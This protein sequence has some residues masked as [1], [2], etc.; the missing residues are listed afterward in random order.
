MLHLSL[1][2][3]AFIAVMPLANAAPEAVPAENIPPEYAALVP[4]DAA[5]VLWVADPQALLD[6]Y[7]ADAESMH[8]PGE[9]PNSMNQVFDY[10][11]KSNVTIPISEPVIIWVDH[12]P[13]PGA[14]GKDV[15]A[16]GAFKAAGAN[17]QNVTALPGQKVFFSGD[18]MIMRK[19]ELGPWS[20]PEKPNTRL[21]SA[22]P[23]ADVVAAFDG[24][25]MS[26]ELEIAMRQFGA[27]GM[28]MAQGLMKERE[29]AAKPE[30]R[31]LV[32]RT[33][34]QGFTAMQRLINGTMDGMKRVDVM[35]LAVNL[36]KGDLQLDLD[37]HYPTRIQKDYGVE[38]SLIEAVPGG[39]PV[40]LA[41]D[42]AAIRWVS[43]MKHDFMEILLVMDAAQIKLYEK[44]GK[45][46][47]KLTS[48]LNNGIAGGIG[49]GDRYE[50]M[51]MNVSDLNTFMR[52]ADELMKEVNDLSI[53]VKTKQTSKHSWA[54][55]VDGAKIAKIFGGTPLVQEQHAR[56]WGGRFDFSFETKGDR[57][58]S[59]RHPAGKP[60]FATSSDTSVRDMLEPKDG[61]A[62]IA[63]VS[64]N[65]APLMHA[66]GVAYMEE[67]MH[68][69]LQRDEKGNF[70][71]IPAAT[72]A[73]PFSMILTNPTQK[74]LSLQINIAAM[75]A[76]RYGMMLT[77]AG[78]FAMEEAESKAKQRDRKN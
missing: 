74:S 3:S 53:G 1:S 17:A 43:E 8:A 64:M 9:I 40:Y 10:V 41:L 54:I 49:I 57:I 33:Q 14:R 78:K 42:Q 38:M 15:R 71:Q 5:V 76:V 68:Q 61:G 4:E 62:L 35:T 45:Q 70:P 21:T 12:L 34:Q 27:L 58:I 72:E 77:M 2:L 30:D 19:A 37:M 16:T 26:A 20:K 11:F 29:Q 39:M 28:V 60:N 31:A 24:K 50:W 51:V 22:L 13:K 75:K 52:G 63:G 73:I 25:Q 65:L 23:T 32:K 48:L 44:M 69:N 55:D 18:M 36:K 46:A 59:K 66:A 47:A 67:A 56:S 6:E 7:K